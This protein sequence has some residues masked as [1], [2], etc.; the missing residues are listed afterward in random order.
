MLGENDMVTV[1]YSRVAAFWN[2]TNL[3]A[4]ICWLRGSDPLV[5][6]P[7]GEWWRSSEST[8]SHRSYWYVPVASTYG[9]VPVDA[10]PYFCT[11]TI[12][13]CGFPRNCVVISYFSGLFIFCL[14]SIRGALWIFCRYQATSHFLYNILLTVVYGKR[15]VR[16]KC[17]DSL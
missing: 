12:D 13:T 2:R 9:D 16:W 10:P 6:E 8:Y 7:R 1:L 3:E 15:H 5:S 11:I 14:L 17:V 4:Q